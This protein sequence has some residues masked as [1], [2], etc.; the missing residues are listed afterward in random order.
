M[1]RKR[2]AYVR[3]HE[4][5]EMYG[6]FKKGSQKRV[7]ALPFRKCALSGQD[8]DTP[9]CT[10]DGFVFELLNVVPF[11][12]QQHVHPI[13]GKPLEVKDLVRLRAVRNTDGDLCCPSTGKVFNDNTHIVAIR[14]TGNVF[15]Y[16]AVETLNIKAK[17][18]VC[19]WGGGVVEE[20]ERRLT[21]LAR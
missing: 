20:E 18:G 13:T 1:G 15:A 7:K 12:Q 21:L 8:W 9:V 17:V 4:W 11:V 5:K 16:E 2:R 3:Q 6:G 14:T 10:E 19:V